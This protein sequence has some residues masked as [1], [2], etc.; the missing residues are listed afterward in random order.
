MQRRLF[1]SSIQ[2]PIF[3]VIIRVPGNIMFV[4]EVLF[5]DE[6]VVSQL[7]EEHRDKETPP[8]LAFPWFG[9]QFLSHAFVALEADARFKHVTRFLNQADLAFYVS[10][11]GEG[12]ETYIFP[13]VIAIA[14]LYV[15]RESLQLK[16]SFVL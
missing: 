10:G 9:S 2:N 6:S 4:T 8:L 3:R 7:H 12:N 5:V 13:L 1:E 15:Y 11:A 16:I 14:S